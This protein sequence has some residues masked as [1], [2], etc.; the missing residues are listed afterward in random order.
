[1]GVN[2]MLGVKQQIHEVLENFDSQESLQQVTNN[3]VLSLNSTLQGTA[4]LGQTWGVFQ[5]FDN[6]IDGIRNVSIG[7]GQFPVKVQSIYVGAE[8]IIDGADSEDG[9]NDQEMEEDRP[10]RSMELEKTIIPFDANYEKNLF[11]AEES[12]D[13]EEG[14]DDQEVDRTKRNMDSEDTR[15]ET[16]KKKEKYDDYEIFS[17]ENEDEDEEE[18]IKRSLEQVENLSME[19]L[20]EILENELKFWN[21]LND[22]L[23]RQNRMIKTDVPK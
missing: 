17:E 21:A 10:K 19:E 23:T 11:K 22:V 12:I 3:V 4:T 1:M 14:T 7:L 15:E 5:A 2:S 6:I 20:D 16:P 9:K 8:E 18:R 13:T